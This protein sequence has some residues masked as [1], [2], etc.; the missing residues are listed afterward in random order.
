MKKW[1]GAREDVGLLGMPVDESFSLPLSTP[2]SFDW[3]HNNGNFVTSIKNQYSP[4]RCGSCFVFAPVAAFESKILISWNM[5]WVDL[6]LSEQI[7]LSCS[8]AGDCANGGRAGDSAD[9]IR[10]TGTSLETCY[11]YTGANGN[12]SSACAHW[13]GNAYRIDGWSLVVNG[14]PAD[15]S[16]IKN[17][18]Y[19]NGPVVAWMK[20]YQDF[21]SYGGGV[22][23]YATGNFSAN[24][25]V[26]IVGWDDSKG[27]FRCKNSWDTG[28]GEEGFFWISYQEL[29]GTGTTEFGKWVYALGNVIQT[30]ITTGP[31][32]TGEWIS[33]SQ[34]C[35]PSSKGQA[36]KISA[37][38]QVNN[39]GSQAVS[40][41]VEVYLSDGTSYLKRISTGKIKAGGN[42]PISI[43]YA[44]PKNQSATGKYL[45]AVIDPD[46]AV[47]EVNEKNNVIFSEIFR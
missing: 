31:D 21:S 6:D 27:A 34:T 1:T 10:N 17:A 41:Y 2:P 5:P 43:S 16:A 39:I 26:L 23:S 24:H 46:D 32:L 19:T 8:E 28:W 35:K 29:Y 25:F 4:Q 22:Y 47:V 15:L 36:C 42:K 11:P 20:V 3:T 13:Q 18:L 40:S 37:K 44:L 12:C 9:F 14:N 33:S 30:P 7:V 38:L 45:I